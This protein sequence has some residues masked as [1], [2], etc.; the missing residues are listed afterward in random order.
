MMKNGEIPLVFTTVDETRTA[1][2]DCYA[3]RRERCSDQVTYYTT[4]GRREG[5]GDG[6]QEH[7]RAGAL[8]DAGACT[9]G[10]TEAAARSSTAN[11]ILHDRNDQNADDRR[12]CAALKASCTG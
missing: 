4:H 8:C 1:I 6:M 9:S 3:I 11:A 12:R 10:C 2:Q 7:A 5:R